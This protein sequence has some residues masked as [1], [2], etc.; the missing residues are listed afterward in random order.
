MDGAL[1]RWTMNNEPWAINDKQQTIGFWNVGFLI[2]LEAIFFRFQASGS[3]HPEGHIGI[4]IDDFFMKPRGNK[5]G[6]RNSVTAG[7]PFRDTEA[8][9]KNR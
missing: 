4:R 2:P 5:L 3:T 9:G 6:K 8:R 1:E 7:I